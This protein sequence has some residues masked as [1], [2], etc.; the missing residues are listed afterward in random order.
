MYTLRTVIPRGVTHTLLAL[1]IALPAAAQERP[2]QPQEPAQ[3]PESERQQA[4][5]G[6]SGQE[7]PATRVD[8][9]IMVVGSAENLELIGGSAE[10]LRGADL[11]RAQQGFGDIHRILRSVPGIN[12]QEEDG[13][14]LRPNIGMRGSGGERSANITL[15]EDGVLIAPAPYAAPSAYYFPTAARMEA[16]E[17]RKGSSQIKFGPR[18]NGGALNLVSTRVPDSNLDLFAN[19]GGGNNATAR[20]Q[21]T[22]GG[23]AGRWGWLVESY[24]IRTDGFKEVDGGGDAGF[25]LSDYMGKLRYRSVAR[26]TSFH[27]IEFKAGY[28]NQLGDETYLG[29]T[30]LDFAARPNRR[31]AGSQLDQ[32]DLEHSQIQLRHY[33]VLSAALDITT[34]V[35]RNDFRRDWY[36][37]QS[38]GGV[39]LS[40]VL[41]DPDIYASEL[42]ILRGADSTPDALKQRHN[43]RS[44]YGQGIQTVLGLHAG[45]AATRHDVEV[46]VRYHLDQEDRF[47][48]EDGYQMRGGQK[49][50]TSIGAPGSQ[51]NRVSDARAWALFVQ[52]RTT[53]GK[54]GVTPG[55]RYESIGMT[56]TDYGKTDPG[57]L[58]LAPTRI[59][60]SRVNVL[61]PGVGFDYRLE[62]NSM[63]F[64]GVHRGFAPPAPGAADEV[65]EE[66][67][68]NY[69]VG[70]RYRALGGAFSAAG[71]FNDYRNLLGSD[72]LSGGGQGTGD[73]FNGGRARVWGAE[74]SGTW[75]IASDAA[76]VRLPMSLG[77]TWTRGEFR[78]SFESD[79]EPWGE[80]EAGD[81]IPYL[82]EHQLHVS[83]GAQGRRWDT[84][85]TLTSGSAMRTVAGRG[86]IAPGTGTDAFTVVDLSAGWEFSEGVRLSAT[87][88]NAFDVAYVAARR[89]AGVRPGLSRTIAVGVTYRR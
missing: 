58:R 70:G 31:Y 80:V 76:S 54:L 37:L 38:V 49:M 81:Q 2:A 30:D 1:A 89:P 56:R 51:T 33:G 68:V 83:A 32:I 46:G 45:G 10:R 25:R 74:V 71:F 72:T 78:S 60:D 52:D 67:S 16:V 9:M 15:M 66:T 47:Q 55:V 35:Y 34:V 50:L 43:N 29:L 39:S 27:E 84:Y 40:A 64:A 69:E 4:Q 61:V 21:L 63:L 26:G 86:T 28:T 12:I 11:L 42:A 73:Q 44:Y 17:V 82:P 3:Q 14:G 48:A 36:K 77:Y 5:A 13:Y 53:F 79:Y 62:S 87:L 41:D 18:T 59:R 88:Q 8:E 57:R 20:G 75:D 7:P 23:N 22:L 85:A 6:Q 65:E 24:Q 19:L